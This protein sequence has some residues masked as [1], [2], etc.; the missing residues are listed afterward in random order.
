MEEEQDIKGTPI[1]LR[2]GREKEMG[3]RN[4]NPIV[5]RMVQRR[6]WDSGA[7]TLLRG[8]GE[9]ELGFRGSNFSLDNERRRWVSGA[10]IFL[11]NIRDRRTVG[12]RGVN[13]SHEYDGEEKVGFRGANLSHRYEGEKEVGFRDANLTQDVRERRWWVS[14][15]QIFLRNMR[16]RRRW[17]S[18][19][20][21][22]FK[23]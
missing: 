10:P 14:G 4:T 9:E 18:G 7:S 19:T 5:R 13:L 12:F 1:F 17:V 22:L 8:R 15:A 20:Q 16:D 11:R 21:I 6:R 23:I 2:I 3:V